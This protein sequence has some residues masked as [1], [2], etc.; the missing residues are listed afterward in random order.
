MALSFFFMKSYVAVAER[1]I[2][3]EFIL[4]LME[5]HWTF[6]DFTRE[7]NF[8]IGKK[9]NKVHFASVSSASRVAVKF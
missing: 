2:F 3:V 6:T 9:S 4:D 7:Y 8:Q 5:K 1:L